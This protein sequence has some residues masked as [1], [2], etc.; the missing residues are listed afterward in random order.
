MKQFKFKMQV[1]KLQE[2]YKIGFS[3]QDILIM[4]KELK[5]NT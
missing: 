2:L 4:L 1:K 5:K 3:L